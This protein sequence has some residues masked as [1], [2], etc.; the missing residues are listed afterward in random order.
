VASAKILLAGE[1]VAAAALESALK[2]RAFDALVLSAPSLPAALVETEERLQS[3]SAE[4]AVAVG[5]SEEALALAIS[6]S[7]LGVPLAVYVDETGAEDQRRILASLAT[8]QT[9][10]DVERAAD[11]IA[12]WLDEAQA[13]PDLD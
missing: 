11:V 3:E 6:A 13:S 2:E 8:L 1:A 4:A 5:A 7:K 12:S 10:A 9:D